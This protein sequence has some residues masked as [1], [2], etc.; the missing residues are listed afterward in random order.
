MT[1]QKLRDLRAPLGQ[2]SREFSER[3]GWKAT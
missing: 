3:L 1:Y 2:V